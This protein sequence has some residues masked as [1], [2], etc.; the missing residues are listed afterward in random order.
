MASLLVLASLLVAASSLAC[1]EDVSPPS[2]APLEAGPA[3]TAPTALHRLTQTQLNYTLQDLFLT[4]EL[5]AVELPPD[6]PVHGFSNNAVTRQAS[7][8]LVESLQRDMQAVTAAA[9]DAPGP[10]LD[11]TSDGGSDPVACGHSTL[12]RMIRRAFRRQVSQDE[13]SW[14]LGR[15]DQWYASLGFRPAME[16]ALQT[17]L[18]TPDFLYIVEQPGLDA[19]EGAD[20]ST[21]LSG[22]EVASRMSYFLWD[23]M[24]DAE[25]FRAA[26]AGELDAE[27]GVR[28]QAERMLANSRADFML[29]HFFEQW[30]AADLIEGIVIDPETYFSELED[31]EES[32]GKIAAFRLALDAE[33]ELFLRDFMRDDGTLAGLLTTRQ[34]WATEDTADYYNATLDTSRSITI[35]KFVGMVDVHEITMYPATLPAD[36]R[37]GFLTSLPFLVGHAH[38][39]FPSPVLRG[40]FVRERILCQPPG[41]PPDDVPPIEELEGMEPKTNRDRYSAHSNNPACSVCHEAIDGVG[42]PFEHYDSLGAWRDQDNGYPVDASGAVLGTDVDGPVNGAVELSE[43]LA[44]SRTAHDCMVKQMYRYAMH[45]NEAPDDKD[46]IAA[47]QEAFWRDGG[48]IE[49]MLVEIVASEAFRTRREK[50]Q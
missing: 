2:E 45:R 24:P 1:S 27:A 50:S 19:A 31:E 6:I 40:V 32:G 9:M 34:T 8:F 22:W 5:P 18:Q 10:W 28:A 3:V 44:T 13:L 15:F 25:L 20:G 43:R 39:V 23:S 11:C 14:I 7:P 33:F 49:G 26:A 36:Q 48:R 41:S 21:P 42:F 47:L 4:T 38:P 12:D 35:S 17:L 46:S 29:L 16:L 37:A 30:L